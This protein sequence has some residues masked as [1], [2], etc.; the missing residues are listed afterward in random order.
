[1]SG[2]GKLNVVGYGKLFVKPDYTK[3]IFKMNSKNENYKVALSELNEKVKDLTMW[4]H[5]LGFSYEEIKTETYRVREDSVYDN[6]TKKFYKTGYEGV[7]TLSV[8]FSIDSERCSRIIDAIV[9]RR[10]DVGI[11]VEFFRFDF[12]SIE[13]ELIELALNDAKRKAAAIAKYS[14]TKLKCILNIRYTDSACTPS[15]YR[16]NADYAAEYYG[17]STPRFNPDDEEME[18]MIEVDWE[19]E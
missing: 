5:V 15:F 3:L 16:E 4:I 18:R 9:E 19:L 1:M 8:S 6:K 13:E 2:E 14:G 10:A 12:D 17:E 11:E 7:S